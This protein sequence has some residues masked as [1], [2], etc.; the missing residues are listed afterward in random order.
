[1]SI[2][3][4]PNDE[5]DGNLHPDHMPQSNLTYPPFGLQPSYVAN[6]G[7]PQPNFAHAQPVGYQPSSY[8]TNLPVS[9]LPPR[10][11]TAPPG[12]ANKPVGAA[13]VPTK[14]YEENPPYCC[15]YMNELF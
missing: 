3:K 4:P 5:P 1:M 6:A 11:V 9:V 13:R 2:S 14:L 12:Y 8:I 10:Y 15:C 7:V